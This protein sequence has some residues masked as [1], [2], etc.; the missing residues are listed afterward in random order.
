VEVDKCNFIA[1]ENF[2]DFGEKLLEFLQENYKEPPGCFSFK[3]I[4][5]KDYLQWLFS[6][7]GFLG[8]LRYGREWV[9]VASCPTKKMRY[10]TITRD[11][12]TVGQVCIKEGFRSF[13]NLKSLGVFCGNIMNKTHGLPGMGPG[14]PMLPFRE[15]PMYTMFGNYRIGI[16]RKDTLSPP[17]NKV[18]SHYNFHLADEKSSFLDR[19]TEENGWVLCYPQ[20][21]KYEDRLW[22]VGVIASYNTSGSWNELLY[23]ACNKQFFEKYDQILVYENHERNFSLLEELGFESVSNY[24]LYVFSD[25]LLE[26]YFLYYN[27]FIL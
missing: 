21:I 18:F 19:Y 27:F 14:V 16:V 22:N 23:N 20:K 9:G 12:F 10:K 15:A 4:F 8:V 11:I 2:N 25:S 1:I 5:T 7:G 24:S 6:D 3:I 13:K 26:S 17:Q